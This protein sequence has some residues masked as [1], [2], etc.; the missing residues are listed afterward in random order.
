MIE[1]YRQSN[2]G[3]ARASERNRSVTV[4]GLAVVQVGRRASVSFEYREFSIE[5]ILDNPL[6]SYRAGPT[7]RPS[8]TVP[9][10]K[11]LGRSRLIRSLWDA[12]EF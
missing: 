7:D 2:C 1:V 10:R 9:Y 5:D 12:L 11:S 6:H 8:A 3:R 4:R